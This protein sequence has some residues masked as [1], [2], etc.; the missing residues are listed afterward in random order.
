VCS[1]VGYEVLEPGVSD[2]RVFTIVIEIPLFHA[3]DMPL[4]TIHDFSK[5]QVEELAS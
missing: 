1:V 5:Q 2:F 4:A 3:Y